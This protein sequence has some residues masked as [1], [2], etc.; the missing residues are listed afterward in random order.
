MKLVRGLRHFGNAA[1]AGTA[2]TIGNFDGVHLGHQALVR[3]TV[4]L[5]RALGAAPV[6]LS[7]EPTPR[8]YFSGERAPGRVINLRTKLQDL[9]QLGV[10]AVVLQRFGR[11]FAAM[12]ARDFVRQ[13]LVEQLGAR[14]VVI[15]DDFRFGARRAGDLALLRE[16]GA[17]LGFHAEGLGSVR[18]GEQRCSSTALREALA[19]PDLAQAREMLGHDYRIVGRVRGGLRLGR[20]LGMPTANLPLRRAPALCLGVYAVDVRIVRDGVLGE[21]RPAVANLGVRPTLG[22]TRCLLEA[23][24]LNAECDLYG[25]VLDVEFRRFLRPELRFDSVES[26]AVQMQA[27]K[28]DALAFFGLDAA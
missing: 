20:R 21:P 24:L 1:A 8:E 18:I 28:R 27:D 23:H 11:E 12:E 10:D 5:A 15:G 4:E 25:E 9:Q 16:E 17:R 3:R 7:F 19:R 2:V 13:A 14:A 26:L 6:V 22:L